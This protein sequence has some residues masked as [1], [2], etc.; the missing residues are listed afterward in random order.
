MTASTSQAPSRPDPQ[1]DPNDL[2]DLDLALARLDGDTALLSD[3]I[4]LFLDES[5]YGLREFQTAIEVRGLS[6]LKSATTS[7]RSSASH[8]FGNRVSGLALQIE[9]LCR[10]GHL[11]GALLLA[12]SFEFELKM[13]V[14]ALQAERQKRAR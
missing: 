11:D 7:L 8:F 2:L 14:N 4:D 9:A 10:Q 3:L 13:L 5:S 12:D 1:T 6:R